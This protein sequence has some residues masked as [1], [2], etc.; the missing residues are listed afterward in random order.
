MRFGEGSLHQCEVMIKVG[1]LLRRGGSLRP[2][3]RRNFADWFWA[4][5]SG[6]VKAWG[7]RKTPKT[8][9]DQ[10]RKFMPPFR[11]DPLPS[12]C[13]TGRGWIPSSVSSPLPERRFFLPPVVSAP[14][15]QDIGDSKRIDTYVHKEAP[16]QVWRQGR[17]EIT[18]V[19]PA[20]G[21]QAAYLVLRE[22]T[23]TLRP[24]ERPRPTT[25]SGCD[26]IRTDAF[27]LV[28]S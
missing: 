11:Q 10:A 2:K 12:S 6:L 17:K 3:H 28:R 18:R 4:T 1:L 5:D 8:Q 27:F 26:V 13:S 21:G 20:Q 16:A 22:Q 24:R 14:T 19:R 25:R 7:H 9:A 15:P 23:P